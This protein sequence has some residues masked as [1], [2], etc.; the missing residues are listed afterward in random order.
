[1]ERVNIVENNSGRL[2]FRSSVR[3]GSDPAAIRGFSRISGNLAREGRATVV[4]RFK[5]L[6]VVPFR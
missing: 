5:L 2:E 3:D 1:M 4:D 6:P